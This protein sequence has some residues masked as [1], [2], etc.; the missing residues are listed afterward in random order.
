MAGKADVIIIGSVTKTWEKRELP[1]WVAEPNGWAE[2]KSVKVLKGTII[3]HLTFRFYPRKDEDGLDLK[4]G[5]NNLFLL[6]RVRGGFTPIGSYQG[7]RRV[8]EADHF[9]E[10]SKSFPI[11]VTFLRPPGPIFFGKATSL[12]FMVK[13]RSMA[14]VQILDNPMLHGFHLVANMERY[15][16]FYK[17]V[18]S[19]GGRG[20]IRTLAAGASLTFTFCASGVTPTNWEDHTLTPVDV[21]VCV[22][23]IPAGEKER[24]QAFSGWASTS[25]GFRP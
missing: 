9:S 12:S 17:V 4:V 23:F 18:Q 21:R 16:S 24:I 3:D 6:E 10:L 22:W 5:Q 13:N 7:V 2:I 25:V 20:E 14:S 8:E 15:G 19:T 11:E 1:S